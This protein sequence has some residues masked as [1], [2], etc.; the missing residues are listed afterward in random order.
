MFILCRSQSG[1][2]AKCSRRIIPHAAF[3]ARIYLV[4]GVCEGEQEVPE[5]VLVELLVAVFVSKSNEIL[6]QE[7][8]FDLMCA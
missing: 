3:A 6:R 5:F 8:H 7:E 2:A 1:C 4:L